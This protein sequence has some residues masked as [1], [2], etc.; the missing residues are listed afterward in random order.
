MGRSLPLSFSCHL[1]PQGK[2]DQKSAFFL[3]LG[4][5]NSFVLAVLLFLIHK[6]CFSLEFFGSFYFLSERGGESCF[7]L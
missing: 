7:R 6:V 4:A 2:D 5:G 1:K 3:L